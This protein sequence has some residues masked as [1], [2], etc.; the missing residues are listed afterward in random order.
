V[1]DEQREQLAEIRKAARRVGL[2]VAPY[3]ETTR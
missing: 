3:R 2:D 1:G